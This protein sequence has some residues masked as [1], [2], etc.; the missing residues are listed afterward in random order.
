MVHVRKPRSV[1]KHS[2]L[3]FVNC[4]IR[5]SFGA[6][7]I[8]CAAATGD[9]AALKPG[10]AAC[11]LSREHRTVTEQGARHGVPPV[12][13]GAALPAQSQVGAQT[14]HWDPANQ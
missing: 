13:G 7:A 10:C 4:L 9:S 2:W 8:S 5:T 1:G 3:H 12:S 14:E 6:A 11:S